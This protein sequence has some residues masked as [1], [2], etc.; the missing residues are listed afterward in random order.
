MS[1]ILDYKQVEEKVF[2]LRG[3]NVLLDSSV[4][5]LYGVETKRINEAVSNNPDKFPEGYLFALDSEEWESLRSKIST[6]KSLGRG[7]HTNTILISTGC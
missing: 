3:E 4:A 1:E 5:E 6:L 7:Q 2:A